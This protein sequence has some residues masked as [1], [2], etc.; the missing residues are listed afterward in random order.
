MHSYNYVFSLARV[1]IRNGGSQKKL[2]IGPPRSLFRLLVRSLAYSMLWRWPAA[3]AATAGRSYILYIRLVYAIISIF[4]LSF[5]GACLL[6]NCV[7]HSLKHEQYNMQRQKTMKFQIRFYL[8]ESNKWK[9]SHWLDNLY[10]LYSIII[11]IILLRYSI[12][13]TKIVWQCKAFV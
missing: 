12:S 5:S 6:Q 11:S 9:L 7:I 8:L 10:I 1:R 2:L 3:A 4:P 13:W